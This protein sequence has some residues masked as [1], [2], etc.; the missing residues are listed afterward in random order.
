MKKMTTNKAPSP[1]GDVDSLLLANTFLEDEEVWNLVSNADQDTYDYVH[2]NLHTYPHRIQTILNRTYFMPERKL[3]KM[4]VVELTDASENLMIA[5][6]RESK[7]H[8]FEVYWNTIK[9]NYER[10]TDSLDDELDDAW[11]ALSAAR[12]RMTEYLAKKKSKYVPPSA[13][14]TVDL[15][16][17]EIEDDIAECKKEFE[18]IEKRIQD[19]DNEYLEKK[20]NERFEAWLLEVQ[21]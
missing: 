11:Q 13:R 7:K 18:N 14:K 21:A 10:P 6:A 5:R 9:D 17:K 4:K 8:E 19:A 20:K 12:D 16:Q 15:D 2:N 1:W 3:L